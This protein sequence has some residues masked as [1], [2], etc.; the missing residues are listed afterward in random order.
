MPSMHESALAKAVCFETL[1]GSNE[2]LMAIF[3]GQLCA[4]F[5]ADFETVKTGVTGWK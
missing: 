1:R 2:V 4:V 3:V 5:H